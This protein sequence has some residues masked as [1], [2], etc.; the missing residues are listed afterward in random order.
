MGAGGRRRGPLLLELADSAG[1]G[2]LFPF[3]SVTASET[4]VS[5]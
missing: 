2:F 1:V 5:V 3:L 4:V